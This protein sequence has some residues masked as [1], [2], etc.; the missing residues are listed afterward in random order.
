MAAGTDDSPLGERKRDHLR[1]SLEADVGFASLRT[2]L[3]EVGVMPCALPERDLDEVDLS[4]AVWG[5]RLAAPL[6]VSC[7]TGGV[8][9]AGPVNRALAEA[10][11]HHGV[12]VGLGSGRVLLKGGDA[13]SFSVRDV[14][15]DVLLL[16]N[17]GAVQLHE[18][19]VDDCRRLLAWCEADVLV[20]HCNA[21]QEAVQPGGDTVFGGLLARLAELCAR[22]EAPVVVKEVGFGLSPAD[23]RRLVEAGVAGVDVAGAGG[24]NWARIEGLRDSRA[25]AVAAAFADW[26]L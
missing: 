6:L 4:V 13:A 10:A 3:E 25:G 5:K 18:Y 24:T 1:L 7:M 26:G 22:L 19:S 20:L 21:V 11:Q 16:A 12:A 17:L 9:E 15:P 14:A 23:V 2:G 8:G